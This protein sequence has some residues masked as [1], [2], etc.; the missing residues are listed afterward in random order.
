MRIYDASGTLVRSLIDAALP[1]GSHEI[2]WD[3]KDDT[4]RSVSS[5]VYLVEF[6]SC[7][8]KDVRK[9]VCLR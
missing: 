1:A 7:G 4:G 5:G 2:R 9:I 8:F 6:E 3:G